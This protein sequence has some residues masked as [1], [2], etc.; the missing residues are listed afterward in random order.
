M[1]HWKFCKDQH[2]ESDALSVSWP[3]IGQLFWLLIGWSWQLTPQH[4][5]VDNHMKFILNVSAPIY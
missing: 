3:L 1:H 5:S 4:R 2:Q